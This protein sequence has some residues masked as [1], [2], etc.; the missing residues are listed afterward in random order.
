MTT[1]EDIIAFL[2]KLDRQQLTGLIQEAS[3]MAANIASTEELETQELVP[4]DLPIQSSKD[5]ETGVLRIRF[6]YAIG[7]RST[8]SWKTLE[9]TADAQEVLLH[10]FAASLV[11]DRNAGR[12]PSRSVNLQRSA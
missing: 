2:Q 7:L 12:S 4:I 5:P 6:P 8:L 9:V 3:L 11:E 10:I 1:N